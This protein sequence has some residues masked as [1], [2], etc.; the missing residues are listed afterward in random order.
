MVGRPF[1]LVVMYA[2]R[3]RECVCTE[4]NRMGGTR[5]KWASQRPRATLRREVHAAQKA[6]EAQRGER[7]LLQAFHRGAGFGDLRQLSCG[8]L[9]V[10]EEVL[11]GPEGFGSLAGLLQHLTQVKLAQEIG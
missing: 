7:E 9:E 5:K 4:R 6:L 2:S 3:F 10:A 1:S 11:V 8:V